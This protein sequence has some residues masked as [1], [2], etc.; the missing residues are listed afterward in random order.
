[1]KIFR[2]VGLACLCL[3]LSVSPAWAQTQTG[4]VAVEA[5]PELTAAPAARVVVLVM[6]KTA[7]AEMVKKLRPESFGGSWRS[8]TFPIGTK[9]RD[10]ALTG[11]KPLFGESFMVSETAQ[12]DAYSLKVRNDGFSYRTDVD[13]QSNPVERTYSFYPAV[14]FA[15]T[16]ELLDPA[17]NLVVTKRYKRV[18]FTRA[19]PKDRPSEAGF[20]LREFDT[21]F[22]KIRDTVFCSYEAGLQDVFAQA[23]IDI[24]QALIAH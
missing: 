12:A 19:C 21:T 4:T 7:Q 1:M 9:L 17:G 13:I 2:S 14:T 15:V 10:G 3:G 18:D 24:R 22:V 23:A 5:V 6:D 8:I 11:F 16:V 20:L